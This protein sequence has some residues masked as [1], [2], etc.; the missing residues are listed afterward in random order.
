MIAHIQRDRKQ[1]NSV[2]QMKA[3]NG[4]YIGLNGEKHAMSLSHIDFI[5]C[6]KATTGA[7]GLHVLYYLP[8]AVLKVVLIHS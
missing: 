4:R 2:C 8:W 3:K 5:T 6:Y 7:L 1:L